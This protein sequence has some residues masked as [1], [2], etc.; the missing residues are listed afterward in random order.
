MIAGQSAL[1]VNCTSLGLHGDEV[2]P[3]LPLAGIGR[4]QVVADVVYRPGGT[5]WLAAAAA[6]GALAGRRAGDAAAPG[7]GGLRAVDRRPRRRSR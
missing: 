2:P 7:R 6:R 3:E 1:V 5:P 4:G